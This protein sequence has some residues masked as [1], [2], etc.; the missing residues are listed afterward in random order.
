MRDNVSIIITVI[1]LITVLLLFPL[2]NYFERQD[3]MTYNIVLKATTNFVDEVVSNGYITQETYDKY[4]NRLSNT[5]YSYDI[6]LEVHRRVLTKDHNSTSQDLKYIEQYERKF[7][8]DIFEE[9]GKT[10]ISGI[11][12]DTQTLKNEAYLLNE[13]D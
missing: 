1:V 10:Q 13:A 6:D 4:I 11:K 5:G 12:K 9:S 8:K 3:D 2:Y 7:N